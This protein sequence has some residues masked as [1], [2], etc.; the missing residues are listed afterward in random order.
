[1]PGDV[2]RLLWDVRDGD[3]EAF[4]RVMDIAYDELRRVAERQLVRERP[5]HTINTT[6]L[7]HEAY[8]KLV[9]QA[10]LPWENRAHFFGIAA[11]AMRQILVDHAR[12]K[13][14]K[15]RGGDR[16]RET[17]SGRPAEQTSAE[18]IAL[19]DALE[20]LSQLSERQRRVVECKFFA[21]MKEE[22]IAEVLG[23]SVRSVQRDWVKARAWL[24]AELY[25]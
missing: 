16:N 6:A 24:N 11:R 20:T 5:D 23:V 8:V 25:G 3:R 13:L 7:V 21:G 9:D 10:R 15:K 14:A 22:E 18:L 19:A 17:L 12:R 2:T 1:M 4:D